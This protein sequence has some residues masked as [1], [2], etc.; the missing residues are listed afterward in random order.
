MNAANFYQPGHTYT[1]GRS[2][3]YGW[4]FRCDTVTTHPEDDERTALGWR[5]FH[6]QWEPYAYGEDD[7]DVQNSLEDGLVD[8][9][10][11]R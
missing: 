9:G 8:E 1:S 2:P 4:K 11:A 10:G 5:F 6:D 3:Q 7:W